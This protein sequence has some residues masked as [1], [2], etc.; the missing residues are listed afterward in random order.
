MTNFTSL[1]ARLALALTLATGAGAA[2]AVPTS[3]HISI[4][5][6]GMTGDAYLDLTFLG[7][8]NSG[9]S[10]A[11]VS[12]FTGASSGASILTGNT[13]GDLATTATFTGAT[14]DAWLDQLVTFGGVFGLDVLFDSALGNDDAANTFAVQFYNMDF[15]EY[16]AYNG[17]IAMI[18]VFSGSTGFT[19]AG[20][21]TTVTA[22]DAA[23]VPEPGQWALM[24]TGL[25]LMGALVRRRTM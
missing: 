24:L 22:N 12:N 18:D 17:A 6:T 23:A 10:T 2:M 8:A 13:T 9:A 4:D 25:L 7:Y 21:F 3:Y 11:V 16:L 14:S 19:T 20:G 1:F 15:S 5:T